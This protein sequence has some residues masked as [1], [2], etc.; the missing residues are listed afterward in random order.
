[1]GIYIY[2]CFNRSVF[3]KTEQFPNKAKGI[4]SEFLPPHSL[5]NGKAIWSREWDRYLSCFNRSV[6]QKNNSL[7]TRQRA[8]GVSVF[9]HIPWN[10]AKVFGVGSVL[11]YQE[12]MGIYPGFN[13]SVSQKC[14]FQ[15]RQK[16]FGVSVF[17]VYPGCNASGFHQYQLKQGKGYLELTGL[18]G[19]ANCPQKRG[20]SP[21]IIFGVRT[22]FFLLGN[23][24][25]LGRPQVKSARIKPLFGAYWSSPPL[26]PPQP[27]GAS[28]RRPL[29]T[30]APCPPTPGAASTAASELRPGGETRSAGGGEPKSSTG[31]PPARCPFS[32]LLFWGRVCL[33]K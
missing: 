20:I 17:Q 9:H 30:S 6:F 4:W 13:R 2:I 12:G 5:N 25:G 16:V 23:S 32:P 1:M 14:S 19:P 29:A 24:E 21:S 15:A 26:P 8:F 3:Q 33:L 7:Q 18:P 27:P 10:M 28:T 11:E 31:I 22:F